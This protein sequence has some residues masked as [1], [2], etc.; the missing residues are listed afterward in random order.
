MVDNTRL[1]LNTTSGDIYRSVDLNGVKTQVMKIDLGGE[2]SEIF[3]A[4][5]QIPIRLFD[6]N[7]N[8]DC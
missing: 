5:G 6:G 4:G 3:P 2:S 7:G 8:G 1:N